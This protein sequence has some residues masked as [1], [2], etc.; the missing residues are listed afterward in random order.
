MTPNKC[1]PEEV[2][3]YTDLP[4]QLHA[5]GKVRDTYQVS[6]SLLM[7]ATDRLSAFDVVLPTPIPSKGW[8]LTQISR[9]WFERTP[10]L[11][12]HLI[13]TEWDVIAGVLAREG[14]VDSDRLRSQVEGRSMLVKRAEPFPVECVVRGYIAGSLWKEYLAAGGL[15]REVVLHGIHLPLG[16][17]QSEQLPEPIF[18]PATKATTGHDENISY[19]RMCQIVGKDNA[20]RLRE[21]SLRLYQEA[22]DYARTR[23][24]IIA[25]TKFEF[26]QAGGEIIL[27]DEVLTPDSS[28]F[29]DASLYTPG[30]PQ[31][32]FDKQFVRDYLETLD[33]DKT[34]PGPELPPD[35]VQKTA[36][37]Y[38]EAYLRLVG[39]AYRVY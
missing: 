5:R 32:S 38:R 29:W 23:G 30:R 9:F 12:N 22:A 27:I 26:G 24:V 25:D 8:V 10:W 14:V 4:L 15:E 3:F 36:E 11:P 17:Q 31:P 16:M 2:I 28:R 37:K 18:T 39:A 19:D 21:Y 33:W 6:D 34:P 1:E 13:S 20:S 7:I 35:I